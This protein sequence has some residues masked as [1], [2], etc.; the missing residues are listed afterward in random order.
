MKVHDGDDVDTLGLDAV[1]EAVWE[2]GDEQTTEPT[3][4]WCARRREVRQSFVRVLNR[5]NE[6]ESEAR[7]F[8]LVGLSGRNELVL[9]FGM[10]LNAP[11]RSVERAFLITFSAG[12]PAAF[13]DL[14]S[15]RR[16]S[17]S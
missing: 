14:S 6:S 8:A 10:E 7:C 16:R 17:A 12:I 3:A 2:F 9:R 1:E 13:P 15:P 4:K 5:C 11:H